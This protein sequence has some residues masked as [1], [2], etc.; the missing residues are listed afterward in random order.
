M[1][2]AQPPF[3]EDYDQEE[4]EVEYPCNIPKPKIEIINTKI[5]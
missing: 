5:Y 3:K 1:E 4:K 2:L